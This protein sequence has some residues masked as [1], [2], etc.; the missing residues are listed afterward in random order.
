VRRHDQDH[1]NPTRS[2]Y[3]SW[4]VSSQTPPQPLGCLLTSFST[5]CDTLPPTH[6]LRAYPSTWPIKLATE[7]V[8]ALLATDENA[9][10]ADITDFKE[11]RSKITS[12]MRLHQLFDVFRFAA[13]DIDL[14]RCSALAKTFLT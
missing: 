9:P 8:D 11:F 12:L 13:R 4:M 6:R 7:W 5:G 10:L 1:H 14:S 2:I 3:I